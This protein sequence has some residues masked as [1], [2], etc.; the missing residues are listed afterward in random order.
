MRQTPKSF[1]GARTCSRSSITE[2]CLVGLGFHQ[3]PGCPKT[4][5]F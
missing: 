2:P 4:L 3:P 1:P 5:S